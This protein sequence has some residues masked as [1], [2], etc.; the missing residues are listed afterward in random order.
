AAWRIKEAL[1]ALEAAFST[2]TE[3]I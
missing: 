1:Q 2:L 3:V